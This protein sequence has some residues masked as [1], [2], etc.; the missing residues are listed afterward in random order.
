MTSQAP[1][2]H[3]ETGLQDRTPLTLRGLWRL[4]R[5]AMILWVLALP[6]FGYFFELWNRAIDFRHFRRMVLVLGAWLA[7][8]LGTMWLNAALDRDEES[9]LF[10]SATPVPDHVDLAGYAALAACVFFAFEAGPG[11]LAC[12]VPCVMLAVLYS[13]PWTVWKGHPLLGPFTNVVG[14]GLLSPVAGWLVVEQAPSLRMVVTFSLL[15]CMVTGGYFAAQAFQQGADEAR[16]YRT[17]VVTAGPERTLR[18][19]RWLMLVPVCSG[20]VL[21]VAGFYPRS[22][23]PFFPYFLW[24]ESYLRRWRAQPD[25][26]DARWASGYLKRLLVGGLLLLA[27]AYVEYRIQY[28]LRGPVA[29]RATS[30]GY[31]GP[32]MPGHAPLW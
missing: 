26:G 5:P 21:S 31:P 12:A 3:R 13:H 20:L 19:A 28:E 1:S 10:A 7:L 16:G 18:L 14:Y 15:A 9:P 30:F 27:V 8:H 2:H 6:L 11:P 32:A 17:L 29:G 25:G 23:L 4:G 24:V 22:C